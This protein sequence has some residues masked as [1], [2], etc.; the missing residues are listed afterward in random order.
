M[1]MLRN[2]LLNV[3]IVNEPQRNP[4]IV[5]AEYD[6]HQLVMVSTQLRVVEKTWSMVT[7]M[8]IGV[9][10]LGQ[11]TAPLTPATLPTK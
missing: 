6:T 5:I 3:A 11:P 9:I 7:S 1:K 10:H 8:S 2:G 4:D